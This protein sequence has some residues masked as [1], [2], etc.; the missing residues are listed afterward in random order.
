MLQDHAVRSPLAAAKEDR[1]RR[2]GIV[3]PLANEKDTFDE[4][5]TRVQKQLQPQDLLFLVFDNACKDGTVDRARAFAAEDPRI[6]VIFAPENRCVVDAYFRGYR[7]AL[8]AGCDWV[9]EMDGGLSHRPE[10]IPRFREAMEQGFDYAG[11]SR[12]V[13]GGSFDGRFS[14]RFISRGGTFLSNTLLGT[15]MRDMTSGFECFTREALTHI[16]NRG[17]RAKRHFFQTEIRTMM[18]DWKWTEVPINYGCPSKSVGQASLKEAFTILFQ[19]YKERKA[20][21]K[22]APAPLEEADKAA[23]PVGIAA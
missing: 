18:H 20:A 22:A 5:F 14:R 3:T 6:K 15:K 12:F 1:M 23:K 11:G 7:E 16:V 4:F 10:E 17:V 8:N 9:L 19:M 21:R 13:E 2:L